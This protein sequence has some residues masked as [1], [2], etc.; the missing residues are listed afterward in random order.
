VSDWLSFS[1]NEQG[2]LMMSRG[3]QEHVDCTE[4]SRLS[5]EVNMDSNSTADEH[6]V[7]SDEFSS[8]LGDGINKDDDFSSVH[9]NIDG[10]NDKPKINTKQNRTNIIQRN[11]LK[12]F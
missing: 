4:S 6:Q 10:C 9:G 2:H 12:L 1:D 3:T 8:H 5:T 11:Q 7:N